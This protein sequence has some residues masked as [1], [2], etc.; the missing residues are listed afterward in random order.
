MCPGR[1]GARFR[2]S[3]RRGTVTVGAGVEVGELLARSLHGT[4]PTFLAG[5][6]PTPTVVGMTLTGA[7]SW[8]G[9]AWGFAANKAESVQLVDAHGLQRTVTS[10]SDPELYWAL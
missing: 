2:W 1:S 10:T 6:S 9:R 8:L 3:P 4:G 5:S 7:M